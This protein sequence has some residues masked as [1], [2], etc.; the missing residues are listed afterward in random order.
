[1]PEISDIALHRVSTAEA[2]ADALVGLIVSGTLPAGEPL[3]ESSLAAKLGVSRNSLREAIRLLERSRL[4]Q[5]EIHRGAI[6]STPTLEDLDDLTRTR[7]QLE[8]AAVRC[9]PSEAQLEQLRAAF[10]QLT[11]TSEQQRAEAIVAADLALHQAIV[12]LLGSERMSS[13]YRQIGKELVFYFTVLSYTDEEYAH[14][15]ASI[16]DRHQ[17][18]IDAILSG[19]RDR[20]H[21]LLAG[22]I[23]ENHERLAEILTARIA[24]AAPAATR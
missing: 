9:T 23:E 24:A 10:A 15:K 3:R 22:H 12:D 1:M 18:I 5:Y 8:L 7:R 2:V 14:P 20:A 16:I 13:F 17:G 21:D 6:V 4:V 11:R 19:D